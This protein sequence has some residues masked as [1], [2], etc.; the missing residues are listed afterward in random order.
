LD[1][2]VDSFPDDGTQI[3]VRSLLRYIVD[4]FPAD[5]FGAAPIIGIR[6][7]YSDLICSLLDEEGH[8]DPNARIR[9]GTGTDIPES[10][11]KLGNIVDLL[12]GHNNT[13]EL[14]QISKIVKEILT[15]RGHSIESETDALKWKLFSDLF[16]AAMPSARDEWKA[17]WQKKEDVHVAFLH[18]LLRHHIA[19]AYQSG[20][21]A[22]GGN[23]S[24]ETM[25]IAR[26]LVRNLD[27]LFKYDESRL[28]GK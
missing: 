25:S 22:I 6:Q 20:W 12:K 28:K 21:A 23:P 13:K 26:A 27:Y 10:L 14:T 11:E 2:L 15:S 7:P 18:P 1:Q 19:H 9:Y 16:N 8:F 4:I 17:K 3:K 5:P 24:M